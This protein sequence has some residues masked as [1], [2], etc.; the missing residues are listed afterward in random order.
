M[1]EY[2]C[3][4]LGKRA[5]DHPDWTQASRSVFVR[6]H[7]RH[8]GAERAHRSPTDQKDP[9]SM[10]FDFRKRRRADAATPAELANWRHS[11][12]ELADWHALLS[13]PD[14]FTPEAGLA[15]ARRHPYSTA[16]AR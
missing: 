3:I 11:D 15:S 10:L 5:A 6:A 8:P 12:Q 9:R 13:T 2:P 4:Y 16:S 1:H 14:T 7:A